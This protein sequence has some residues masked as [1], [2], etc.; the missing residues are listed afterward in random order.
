MKR[1]YISL[2]I[3]GHEDTYGQRLKEAFKWCKEKYPQSFVVTPKDISDRINNTRVEKGLP[4]P[5]YADYLSADLH[6]IMCYVDIVVFCDGWENSRGC[7]IE[8]LVAKEFG[9]EIIYKTNDI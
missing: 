5:S 4:N 2:P 8:H 6:F 3:T 1:I 7:R 9:K